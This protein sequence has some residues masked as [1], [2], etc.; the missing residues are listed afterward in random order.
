MAVTSHM[1]RR[2][3]L[4]QGSVAIAGLAL[5]RAPGLAYAFSAQS[6]EEVLTWLDQPAPNPVPDVVGT[7]LQWEALNSWLTPNEQ[8]FT[9]GH[10]DKPNKYGL[11]DMHGNVLQW[12]H[13]YYDPEYYSKGP[14]FNYDPQG[15]TERPAGAEF[16]VLRGGSWQYDSKDCRSACRHKSLPH[17]RR[18]K[19]FGFRVVMEIVEKKP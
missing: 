7:Q 4:L 12:C 15:P 8:F 17:L 16:R 1:S 10:Y 18:G 9:V 13:D 6:G 5:L 11:H 14:V 19:D 3:V 2:D